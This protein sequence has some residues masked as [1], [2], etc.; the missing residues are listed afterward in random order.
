MVRVRMVRTIDM[1]TFRCVCL[2]EAVDMGSELAK[3]DVSC[4]EYVTITSV[5]L[6]KRQK[7]R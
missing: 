4:L 5:A 3:N 6:S 2:H 7:G 1:A